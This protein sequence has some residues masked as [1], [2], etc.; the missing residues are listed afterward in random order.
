[1]RPIRHLEKIRYNL[2]R[3]DRGPYHS[4][5]LWHIEKLQLIGIEVNEDCSNV[6]SLMAQ[7]TSLYDIPIPKPW[8]MKKMI[9]VGIVFSCAIFAS[10]YYKLKSSV[11]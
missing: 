4:N 5:T 6:D 7:C 3:T 2:N 8:S 9:T 10:I 11:I 1:M